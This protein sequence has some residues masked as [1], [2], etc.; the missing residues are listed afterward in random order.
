M[1]KGMI[2][3]ESGVFYTFRA[4]C[5]RCEKPAEVKGLRKRAL[6]RWQAGALVQNAFPGLSPAEREILASGM[7]DECFN[8]WFPPDPEDEI[9]I[10]EI[11]GEGLY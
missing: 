3:K 10:G 8:A 4:T 7:H 6:D 1:V 5:P 2:I 11:R 9:Y